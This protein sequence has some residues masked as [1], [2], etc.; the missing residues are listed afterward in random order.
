MITN[1]NMKKIII[2][3]LVLLLTACRESDNHFST[4]R[5]ITLEGKEDT[6]NISY[7]EYLHITTSFELVDEH[8]SVKA[9]FVKRF[10]QLQTK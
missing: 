2:A 5:I 9:N 3:A 10:S 8:G 6:L 7:F 4:V 1:N